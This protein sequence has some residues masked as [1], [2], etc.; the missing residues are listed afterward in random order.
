M[1]HVLAGAGRNIRNA[2]KSKWNG[3]CYSHSIVAQGLGLKS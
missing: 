3:V 2:V 1:I